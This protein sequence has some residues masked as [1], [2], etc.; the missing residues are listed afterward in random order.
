MA[1]NKNIIT[2]PHHVFRD[3]WFHGKDRELL[4]QGK[5]PEIDLGY[6]S[7]HDCDGRVR[8]GYLAELRGDL[9]TAQ[10]IYESIGINA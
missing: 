5:W 2:E 10:A 6:I 1:E 4:R 8:Q 7:E 3:K 9:E